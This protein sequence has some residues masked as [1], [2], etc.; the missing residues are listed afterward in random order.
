[1]DRQAIE[2]L[3]TF[4][5]TFDENGGMA[6]LNILA[7]LQ[8]LCIEMDSQ[9]EGI[10]ILP[11][12]LGLFTRIDVL[13]HDCNMTDGNVD[14]E[15]F[16]AMIATCRKTTNLFTGSEDAGRL[17]DAQMTALLLFEWPSKAASASAPGAEV[18][19]GM[20][21]S[22]KAAVEGSDES[23]ALADGSR[24][25]A[26]HLSR[27]PELEELRIL[28]DSLQKLDAEKELGNYKDW[29]QDV[30]IAERVYLDR[31]PEELQ[32]WLQKMRIKML[33]GA[34][35]KE[36]VVQLADRLAR[37]AIIAV[38]PQIWHVEEGDQDDSE[39]EPTQEELL[40]RRLGFIFVAYR[41]LRTSND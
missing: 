32:A 4:F 24:Q 7:L 28:L 15:E 14:Y 25:S 33:S 38:P 35:K 21:K 16:K 3:C 17:S 18:F 37:E 9:S 29:R 13:N 27:D 26:I 30:H 6:F 40:I 20:Q 2:D 34:Q 12:G 36:M 5:Q 1:M 11:R 23:A 41:L 8:A 22:F 31:G 10:L 39:V 19:A